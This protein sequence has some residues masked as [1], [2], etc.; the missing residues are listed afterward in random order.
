MTGVR[1]DSSVSAQSGREN[2]PAPRRSFGLHI[3]ERRLLLLLG[4]L[5]ML[6]LALAASLWIRG[7]WIAEAYRKLGRAYDTLP[8]WWAVLWVLWI[9]SSMI[10]QCYDLRRAA[11]PVRSAVY[12]ATAALL[13]SGLYLLVPFISAPLVYSRLAWFIFSSLAAVGVALWRALYATVFHQPAFR[14]RVLLVG[15]GESGRALVSGVVGMGMDAGIEFIGLVDDRQDIAEIEH[16][17]RLGSCHSIEQLVCE[18]G[19]NEIVVA[20]TDPSRMSSSLVE[21]LVSCW[22]RGLP[23]T[24]MPLFYE[25]VMGALPVEHLGQ[26]A[27]ALLYERSFA[28]K[29]F[30]DVIQRV[31]DILVAI[32]GL[33]ILLP[34][35]PL[36]ALV[37][38]L[39]SHGP[40]F[41]RQ[42]RVGRRGEAFWITKFRSMVPNAEVDGAVWA[43][44]ED[45]RVTR[46]GRIMRSLRI[47]ELPQLWNLLR[48]NMGLIGPRP[49]RPEFVAQL[50][51]QIPYYG[52]RHSIKPGLTGWA[53][54]RYRYGSTV[55][56][57]LTKLQYDLYY[58]KHRGPVLDAAI[59]LKTVRVV[60]AMRGS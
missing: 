54:V 29:R 43:Q 47:D 57:A 59:L 36:I 49:E 45:P 19:A 8:L 4:D 28:L 18:H 9:C 3:S 33:F 35:L 34:F 23:V 12:T 17:K 21:S 38:K 56:D 40:V 11:N 37:I 41:Y 7:P 50:E 2:A 32:L 51:D 15:A 25:E 39:D 48:G 27:F 52:I 53:Q 20:I 5:I 14:R 30:W 1:V 31:V 55:E 26:N 46:V 24:P 44:Q 58:V 42:E 16:C 6:G 13:V 60:L 10:L 22:S